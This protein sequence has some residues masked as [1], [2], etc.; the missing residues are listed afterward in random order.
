MHKFYLSSMLWVLAVSRLKFLLAQK[1]AWFTFYCSMRLYAVI[2]IME[3][4][5]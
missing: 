1:G 2:L 3:L 4:R 5:F